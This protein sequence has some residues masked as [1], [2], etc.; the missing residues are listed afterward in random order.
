MDAPLTLLHGYALSPC[1]TRRA[2]VR[3]LG[4]LGEAID[5][6]KNRGTTPRHIG[7]ADPQS[8]VLETVARLRCFATH[9]ADLQGCARDS[10]RILISSPLPVGAPRSHRRRMGA[11]R[12]QP[13]GEG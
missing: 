3:L 12:E 2:F 9:S 11:A 4:R 10:T 5:C 1:Q 6:G 13:A 7:H 8:G